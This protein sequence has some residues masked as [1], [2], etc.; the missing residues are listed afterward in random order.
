MK[1]R[2]RAERIDTIVIGGGQAGLSVGHH[3]AK[4]G[5]N[6]LIL[7][8]NNRI[9]NAWRN[10]WDSLRLFTPAR[11]VELPGM[12]FPGKG[13]AFPTKDQIADY[14]ESYADRFQLP[15]QCGVKVDRLGKEGE[16]FVIQAGKLRY[17]ADNVVVAMADYQ[18]PKIP[19]FAQDLDPGTLQLH[20]QSYRNPWQLQEGGVLV[21]GVGNSGADIAIDVARSHQTWIAGKESGHIPWNINT[22]FARNVAFRVIRFLGHHVLTLGTPMG[23]KKRPQLLHRATPLIR[24]KPK[25]LIDAGIQ[26]VGRVTGV[27]DGKPLLEDGGTID[28][29]NVI[30]C[31]GYE[32]GF[33]WIDLPAFDKECRPAHER[34]I[35]KVPGLY[36]VGLH[37]QYAMSSA[38]LI[39]VGRDAEYVVKAVVAR[40]RW[41]KRAPEKVRAMPLP[42]SA[43][44]VGANLA[45][46]A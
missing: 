8:A 40:S 32:P 34:G 14:L 13:D 5:I 41:A 17:E 15:V 10:R 42:V 33:S 11:Y 36:F 1:S 22:F 20:P 39:G 35:S 16:H 28:V 7:D 46:E 2:F 37:F 27:Q 3:L 31:T 44:P 45:R 25:D 23:R 19:A 18:V 4:R 26:H 38:T 24:V 6:F 43:D 21:V 9:G 29:R 12:R 30:W